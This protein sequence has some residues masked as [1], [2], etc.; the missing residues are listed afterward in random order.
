MLDDIVTRLEGAVDL[1]RTL[2]VARA[3]WDSDRWFSFDR[4]AQTAGYCAEELRTADLDEVELIQFP[5]DGQT[6][7]GDWTMP[8]AWDARQA[9]LEITEPTDAQP[10]LLADYRETPTCLA[11]WSAPTPPGG[12]QGEVVAIDDTERAPDVAGKI[13]LASR[14]ARDLKAWATQRGAL[15]IVSDYSPQSEKL[16]EA[17]YWTNAWSDA[18]DGWAHLKGN[19]EAWGFSLSPATG[20]RLRE[21]MARHKVVLRAQVDTKLY[22]G[23]VP[24]VT[25]AIRGAEAPDEEAFAFAHL[26]EV[27]A[28]DNAAGC[29]LLMEA[30]RVLQALVRAGDLPPPGKTIRLLLESEC[31]GTVA[32]AQE[33]IRG[34]NRRLATSLIV[35]E[36]TQKQETGGQPLSA[37]FLPACQASYEEALLEA[38]LQAAFGEDRQRRWAPFSLV[39]CICGDPML[40]RGGLW[41][42]QSDLYW[43]T[44]DDTPEKI[45]P[46][47]VRGLTIAVAAYLWSAAN[48]EPKHHNWLRNRMIAFHEA[49]RE[50]SGDARG[51]PDDPQSRFQQEGLTRAATSLPGAPSAPPGDLLDTLGRSTSGHNLLPSRRTVGTLTFEGAPRSEWEHFGSPRWSPA[52]ALAQFWCNGKRTVAEIGTRVELECGPQK[53]NWVEYF[54]FLAKHGHVSLG[55]PGEPT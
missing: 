15:G 49:R 14:H 37:H 43:H 12:V 41:L 31:Y 1:D 54:R 19:C 26:Y 5:A 33:H 34:R 2:E 13:V 52:K 50:A 6:K 27:G 21:P 46:E 20:K 4:F 44:S 45:D 36:A 51:G 55:E 10:K 16:P 32:Y 35:D 9:R 39:D 30:L 23:T 7:F 24:V 38:C 11:M 48:V 25:G 42:G 18:T 40:G 22:E 3:I 53:T 28:N 8:L 29:A 17:T 47:A